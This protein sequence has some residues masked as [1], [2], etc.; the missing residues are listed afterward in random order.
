MYWG[1]LST[2]I[3]EPGRKRPGFLI[4]AGSEGGISFAD[5]FGGGFSADH[6]HFPAV[7]HVGDFGA[8]PT[9]LNQRFDSAGML[10]KKTS[11]RAGFSAYYPRW[12]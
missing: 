10:Q 8:C 2:R 4:R 7:F 3:S 5:P 12:R 1:A 9:S 11:P 6:T